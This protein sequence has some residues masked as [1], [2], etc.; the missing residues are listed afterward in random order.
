MYLLLTDETNLKAGARVEFFS[1]GGLIVSTDKAAELHT[2]IA[3]IRTS[4]GYLPGDK[5][6]FDTNA[7]P[8]HVSIEAAT[9]AKREVIQACVACNCKFIAYVIL[10]AIARTTPLKEPRIQLASA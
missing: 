4:N 5:L 6:K 9:A 2:L 3:G 1:Y 10:H 8:E 7:R